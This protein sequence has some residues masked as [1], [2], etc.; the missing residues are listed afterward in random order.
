MKGFVLG[1]VVMAV[2][3]ALI[4]WGLWSANCEP[5]GTTSISIGSTRVG[6]YTPPSG[7]WVCR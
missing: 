4:G 3:G 7:T 2:V 1:V 5:L 6:S